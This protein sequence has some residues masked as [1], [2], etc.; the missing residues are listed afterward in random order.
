VPALYKLYPGW[1][2]AAKIAATQPPI[3]SFSAKMGIEVKLSFP[4]LF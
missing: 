1:A 4:L 3:I 2:M